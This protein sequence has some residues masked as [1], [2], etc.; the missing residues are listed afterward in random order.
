MLQDVYFLHNLCY[1]Y[2]DI[3]VFIKSMRFCKSVQIINPRHLKTFP[4]KCQLKTF[5][6]NFQKKY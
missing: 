3:I 4:N 1:N 5:F 2:Y 6:D